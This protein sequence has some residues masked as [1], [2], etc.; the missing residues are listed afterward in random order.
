[1]SEVVG[2]EKVK[3]LRYIDKRKGRTTPSIE[4]RPIDCWSCG[5]AHNPPAFK[6]I[7][8]NGCKCAYY[9]NRECQRTDWKNETA[10]TNHKE[11]YAKILNNGVMCT[12]LLCVF[13][14][15]II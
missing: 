3:K 8:C 4:S 6:L 9:C 7:R 1:M 2:R 12:K 15:Q 11:I 14:K 10:A 13:L 5:K